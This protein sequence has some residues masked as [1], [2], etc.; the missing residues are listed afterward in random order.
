[1]RYGPQLTAISLSISFVAEG[2]PLGGIG[3]DESPTTNSVNYKEEAV[4]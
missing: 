1:M 3:L 4:S 2:K